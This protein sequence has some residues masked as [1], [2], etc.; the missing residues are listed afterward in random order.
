MDRPWLLALAGSRGAQTSPAQLGDFTLD[1]LRGES[2]NTGKELRRLIEFLKTEIRPQV[3]SVPNLMFIGAARGLKETLNV[4]VIL[5]LTGEDIFLNAMAEPH[6][7]EAQRII[8][9][10]AK[11]VD[12]FV[13]TSAYYADEMARYLDVPRAKVD[14]VYSGVPADTVVHRPRPAREAGPWTVGH[15]ARICPEKGIDQLVDAV[16]ALRRRPGFER[17]KL[18][19][20]GYLGRANGGW[21]KDLERR[22]H[23]SEMAADY[24]YLGEVTREQKLALIESADVFA[25]PTRYAESKGIYVIESLAR[26]TPVVLPAHGSFPELVAATNGGVTHAPGD[27]EALAGALAEV[28]NDP[29]RRN[30]MAAAGHAAVRERFLDTHMANG[31]LA[32]YRSAIG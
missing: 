9:A 13:A 17:T 19:A 11:D 12:R 30:A 15:L 31:M 29:A 24:E 32:I 2:G 7:S 5:E 18:R 16:T 10:R 4:P 8:R 14:V 20:G 22:V 26:G 23:A 1:I 3:I 27:A 21:Y 28:L 25:V 6:R